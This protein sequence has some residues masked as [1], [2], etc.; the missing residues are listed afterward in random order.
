VKR[1]YDPETGGHAPGDMRDAMLAAIDAFMA[2]TAGAEPEIAFGSDA[3]PVRISRV[4]AY[5]ARC[6]DPL[7]GV[8]AALVSQAAG[9]A[10]PPGATYSAAAGALLPLIAKR[11]I[12][13]RNKPAPAADAA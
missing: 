1:R 2:W 7:P 5:M 12:R 6:T 4:A 3:V 11:T 13:L 8:A 10:L 9:S